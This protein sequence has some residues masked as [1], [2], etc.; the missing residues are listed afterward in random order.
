M[1]LRASF[2]PR[3]STSTPS[4]FAA[5]T[6]SESPVPL[7]STPEST[8]AST[9]ASLIEDT[10]FPPLPAFAASIATSSGEAGQGLLDF[11]DSPKGWYWSDSDPKT[12]RGW[13]CAELRTKSFDDLHKLWWICI[14]E[15]NKLLSQKDE[16]RMFKVIFPHPVR[17][18]QVRV[19]MR[20]IRMVI[21][22]R[23]IAYLQA[24]AIVERETTRQHLFATHLT[25]Y[26]T[27]HNLPEA[28]RIPT[29]A[30][31]TAKVEAEMKK[32][33][34]TPV[35]EIGRKPEERRN[36]ERALDLTA[37]GRK[38]RGGLGEKREKMKGS[39]WTVV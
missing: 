36:V 33:F 21:H 10:P 38:K 8:P 37:G 2:A 14:K 4:S 16:A 24:Q 27:A 12:G 5:N 29:P 9:P 1:A 35:H 23:R 13:T 30:E 18:Q 34:R 6:P 22:E 11:F 28:Q 39:R 3:Y 26:K 32:L 7:E 15:Q 20:G 31:V 17:L 19:T 25:A